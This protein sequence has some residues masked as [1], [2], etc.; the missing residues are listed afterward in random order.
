MTTTALSTLTADEIFDMIYL[1]AR[2]VS[3]YIFAK[4]VEINDYNKLD[5]Y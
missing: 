1:M 5:T 2:S 4:P 3:S